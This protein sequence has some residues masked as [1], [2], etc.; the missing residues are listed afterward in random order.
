ML[1]NGNIEIEC[2]IK[3]EF[4]T[5]KTPTTTF[6]QGVVVD[7]H[8][9]LT[10]H[11][12]KYEPNAFISKGVLIKLRGVMNKQVGG[13]LKVMNMEHVNIVDQTKT[14]SIELRK[15]IHSVLLERTKRK[16]TN[17]HPESLKK[18]NATVPPTSE[19]LAKLKQDNIIKI[20]FIKPSSRTIRSG[21]PAVEKIVTPTDKQIVTPADKQIVTSADEEEETPAPKL[22]REDKKTI[23]E[24]NVE[25]QFEIA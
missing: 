13:S 21:T 6:G 8:D 7:G 25:Q 10:V 24:V 1:H 16:D 19:L 11:I 12:I 4:V 3:N 5:V 9:R 15:S 20:K 23:N 18:I 22:V 17:D 14:S 2:F